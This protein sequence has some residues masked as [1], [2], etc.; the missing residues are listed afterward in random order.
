VNAVTASLLAE[1]ADA[2]DRFVVMSVDDEQLESGLVWLP[3]IQMTYTTDNLSLPVRLGT[4][5]SPGSQDVVLH[6]LSQWSEGKAAVASYPEF[7]VEGECMWEGDG[8]GFDAFYAD[9]LKNAFEETN[10]GAAW[11]TEYVWAPEKCDP[12]TAE[13]PLGEETL[14]ELGYGGA[15]EEAILTRIRVRGQADALNQDLAIYFSG[16]RDSS[17]LRYI[18]YATELESEFPIC[19]SG[20]VDNAPGSCDA[21]DPGG[22]AMLI[23]AAALVPGLWGLWGA[24]RRRQD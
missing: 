16:L 11:T 1:Y 5:A 14:R 18:D 13:G 4:A 20:W 15:P 12:C 21:G 6:V 9:N 3:P 7:E 8:S 2:G 23:P 22:Q 10:G 17:Q 24:A 19:G